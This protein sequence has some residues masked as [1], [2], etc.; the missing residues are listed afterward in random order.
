MEKSLN[1]YLKFFRIFLE[2]SREKFL[3]IGIYFIILLII[4]ILF[5]KIIYKS[6]KIGVKIKNIKGEE[7]QAERI[8]TLS[9]VLDSILKVIIFL[10]FF[11]LVLRE[12]EI[13]LIPFITGL[14]FIGAA[15]VVIFQ[16]TIQDIIKGWLLLFEDQIRKGELIMINNTPQF[17]GKVIK[18]NLRYIVLKDK[19]GNLIF[20]PNSQILSI[21]NLSRETKKF[22]F[23]IKLDKNVDFDE[24]LKDLN[25]FLEKFK[26]ENQQIVRCG[27]EDN[28]NISQD[29]YEL[30][31]SFRAKYSIGE[32]YI[33]KLKL[34]LFNRYKDKI[35]EIL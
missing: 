20:F 35:K 14:G 5:R 1:L 8:S 32:E 10:I 28:I 13:K 25:N 29:F 6:V 33:G 12:F 18:I 9:S 23:K 19:E 2:E 7:V 16:S 4:Y 30:T 27:V 15:F 11:F 26:E 31:I 34:S 22:S 24:F 3:N 17:T 21:I